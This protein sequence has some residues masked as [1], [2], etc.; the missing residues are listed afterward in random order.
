MNASF[1]SYTDIL[2]A[3]QQDS[4]SPENFPSVVVGYRTSNAKD[5]AESNSNISSSQ[6]SFMDESSNEFN[7]QQLIHPNTLIKV[8]GGCGDK[9]SD[10]YLLYALDR[11]WH[12]SCLKCHCCGAMLAD[13]GSS[14]FTRRGLILCKKDYSSMFGS[15][16]VCS[17]CGETIPPSEMVA[18][19]LTGINN[20]DLQNQQKQIINF[21]LRCFSCAKC[22]SNLRPGDRYTMLGA[23]LVCE[24]DWHKLL[25]NPSNSNGTLAQR[26]GK[27]GRP[28]RSKD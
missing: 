7:N 1:H 10:R 20:I 23:S 12:N 11:Y 28:R 8:C 14:C 2:A 4:S 13:V 9:I 3:H 19:A 22:G 17:G 18:K 25:K 24:Q 5:I 16:G 15:S 26:K 6:L 21:H 27:V